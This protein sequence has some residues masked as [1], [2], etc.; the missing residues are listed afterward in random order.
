MH[1]THLGNVLHGPQLQSLIM[2]Y[3]PKCKKKNASLV[4]GFP[5]EG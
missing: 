4:L 1:D 5:S 3:L 2:G